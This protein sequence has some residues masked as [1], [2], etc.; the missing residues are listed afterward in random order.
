VWSAEKG[1]GAGVHAPQAESTFWTSCRLTLPWDYFMF[2]RDPLTK[3]FQRVLWG[4][5]FRQAVLQDLRLDWLA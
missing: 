4:T 2:A 5:A 3:R 1:R